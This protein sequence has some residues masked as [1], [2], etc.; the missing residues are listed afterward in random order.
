MS[1]NEEES[2]PENNANDTIVELQLGDVI[3]ITDPLNEVLNEQTFIIDY[4]DKSK[5]YLINTDTFNKIRLP[6]SREGIIG[7]GTIVKIAILSRS[8]TPSYAR[9][10][11]LLPGKWINIHFGGDIPLI[12]TGEITNLENDMIEIRTV[13]EDVIYLNFDYTYIFISYIYLY[14]FMI[15]LI[16]SRILC[17]LI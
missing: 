13:D 16:F 11:N 1:D 2:K 15:K 8:D 5:A 3:N 10:N 17:L 4:I 6:I 12:I 7:N 14:L 9:Q